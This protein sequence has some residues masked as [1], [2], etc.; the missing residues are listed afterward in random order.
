MQAKE[1]N[2]LKLPNDVY[3]F[4]IVEAKIFENERG[5]AWRIDGELAADKTYS[6]TFFLP[7]DPTPKNK[8]GQFYRSVFGKELTIGEITDD[9]LYPGM[10]RGKSLRLVLEWDLKAEKM[11]VKS[12]LPLK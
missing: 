10:L 5:K 7:Y 6:Y 8:H 3:N 1:Y 4:K 11:F 12:I 9:A 2:S